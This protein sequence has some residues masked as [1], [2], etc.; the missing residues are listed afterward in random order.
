[1]MVACIVLLAVVAG[2]FLLWRAHEANLVT[3]ARA[4]ADLRA[5]NAAS[6]L[7]LSV[8]RGP[9][10]AEEA[11]LR[12]AGNDPEQLRQALV[13]IHELRLKYANRDLD[14]ARRWHAD[15]RIAPEGPD[16]LALV[17]ADERQA[18]AEV[19]RYA[20]A[21]SRIW[22]WQPASVGGASGLQPASSPQA[23]T[24]APIG[25][26]QVQT[27]PDPRVLDQ[28]NGHPGT[29][30]AAVPEVPPAL[31][32]QQVAPM[33][34]GGEIAEAARHPTVTVY[35][36]NTVSSAPVIDDAG[37]A[38]R[39]RNEVQIRDTL[40]RWAHAMVLNDA[41]AEAAEYAPHMDR[42]FLRTDVDKTFVEE[43][44]ASYLR[45]GNRTASFA[46]Q[47]VQIENETDNT[48]DVRLVK[49]VT[50]AQSTSGATHKLIRSQLWLARSG[51]G[52]KITGERD[53]R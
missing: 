40:S 33:P 41:H 9:S 8:V 29:S 50:W 4:Q 46:I 44:K 31:P 14:D 16:R 39:A 23:P 7:A 37:I 45:H 6:L 26:A 30:A 47:D 3:A 5:Q 48:A 27:K 43:D 25:A 13:E 18:T 38:R 42:Y 15:L 35:A 49:D 17:E 19:T 2:A 22:A 24:R 51:S 32:S 53:F 10:A 12:R 36:D 52:W 11:R 21:L 20:A 1:M 28:P 34:S